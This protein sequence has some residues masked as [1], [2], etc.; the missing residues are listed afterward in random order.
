MVPIRL[1]PGMPSPRIRVLVVDDEAPI[2]RAT[3]E[4]LEAYEYDVLTHADPRSVHE[5]LK[6]T[7]ASVLL[8]DVRMPGLDVRALVR[9]VKEDEATA[10]THV[11]LFSAGM[12]ALALGEELGVP[13]VEKPFTP[14]KLLAALRRTT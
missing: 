11:V 4:L 2:L 8:Q 1:L 3:A 12:E 6:Q 9:Q 10:A 14:P 5:T 13:V 7:N